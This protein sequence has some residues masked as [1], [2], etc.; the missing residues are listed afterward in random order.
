MQEKVKNKQKDI[1][2]KSAKS[3]QKQ[4]KGITLIALVITIIVLLILAGVSIATLTG[5]NGILTRA[6]DA[7]EQTQSATAEEKVAVEVAGSYGT[8]G[9][10][11]QDLLNKNLENVEG[12]ETQLPIS[13]PA[14][15]VVDGYEIMIGAN[16]SV[17]T[18]TRIP[19]P[20]EKSEITKPYLPGNDFTV[21]ESSLENG[22]VVTDGTNHWT[23]IEVPT[24]I[25][26]NTTYNGGTAPAG[27]NDY[28]AIETTLNNY[29]GTLV[30][31]GSYTDVWYDRYGVTYNE[32]SDYSQI[33]FAYPQSDN[34][35]AAKE[36]YGAIYTD[37]NGL[38]EATSYTSGTTYYVKI[39]DNL[40]DAGG[41]GLTYEEYNNLKNYMLSSVYTNG[42]FW[43]G[44]YEAG[45][46]SYPATAE[47]DTRELIIQEGAYPYNFITCSNAQIK[48]SGINSGNY[49][50]SL[51]FGIQWDL[52]LKHLE[53]NGEWDESNTPQY[54]LTSNSSDW[55]NYRDIGFDI[56]RGGYSESPSTAN[57]FTSVNGTY[58]K[59]ENSS[60]LLT[61]GATERNNRMN[62]YDL[63][64]NVYEWTLEK[65]T[66]AN[67]PC[68]YRGGSYINGGSY[69]PASSRS[70]RST[71]YSYNIS[72]FRP[73]LY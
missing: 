41:C 39:T 69:I 19:V 20:S 60:V 63:A 67:N 16:G 9:K 70:Y 34:F 48:S 25:Y 68:V 14:T 66:N 28:D 36:L 40:N 49:T 27:A 31:R 45:A 65:G 37:V 61:T 42:G 12:L 72:G 43:I 46:D 55:G 13:L 26:A 18:I 4:A 8:D 11:D 15:V 51:M 22:I 56:D 50:S 32:E 7:R 44:Q 17:G 62:I 29:A 73:A 6:N 24:D 71:S 47:N 52:V 58:Q 30:S 1:R 21:V 2:N 5:E 10:I 53:I 59:P 57:S 3:I 64:G 35:N 54:Y 23:W 38:N 33:S